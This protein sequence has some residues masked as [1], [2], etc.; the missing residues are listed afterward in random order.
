MDIF[1]LQGIEH[2]SVA[3]LRNLLPTVTAPHFTVSWTWALGDI[4]VWDNRCTLHAGTGFNAA[5][6]Q[7]KM[8]RLSLTTPEPSTSN[9]SLG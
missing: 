9:T 5:A 8:S 6:E 1:D 4:V 7:R 2:E 3:T